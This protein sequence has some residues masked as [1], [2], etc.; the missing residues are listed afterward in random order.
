MASGVNA[1]LGAFEWTPAAVNDGVT[2]QRKVVYHNVNEDTHVGED[3]AADHFTVVDV[4][5]AKFADGS[6]RAGLDCPSTPYCGTFLDFDEDG[7]KDLLVNESDG[8]SLIFRGLW[9][10]PSGVPEFVRYFEMP[11]IGVRGVALANYDYDGDED[12]FLTHKTMPTLYRNDGGTFVDVTVAVGLADLAAKSTAA[13]RGDCDNDGWLD[14]Y[15]VRS[16]RGYSELREHLDMSGAVHRWFRSQL[17]GI[18]NSLFVA[19]DT[20]MTQRLVLVQ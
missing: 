13:W 6:S 20:A 10:L 17:G 12:I 18:G 16:D 1:M 8:S 15:V 7:H 11:A 14:L 19:G 2:T 9:I 5:A 4:T 3:S